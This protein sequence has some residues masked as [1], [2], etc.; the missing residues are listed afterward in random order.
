VITSFVHALQILVSVVFLYI[1]LVVILSEI[2]ATENLGVQLADLIFKPLGTLFNN[3]VSYLPTLFNIAVII[4]FARYLIKAIRY[5]TKG[6]ITG[7][8]R[9]PGLHP[10]TARTTGG[11]ITALVYILTVI[12]ILPSMPG[13]GSLAF[14]GI[15]TFLGALITI[16]GSSVIANYMAGIVLTYM[17]AFDKGDWVEMDGAFGK[18]VATGPFAVQVNTL[19]AETI[20]IPNAK[21]LSTAIR[22]YTGRHPQQMMLSAE[23]SIGYDVSWKQVNALLMEA[24]QR[25]P[26]LDQEKVP[27]VLQ[28]KLD[29]FYIVYEL[30]VYLNRPEAKLDVHSA[31]HAHI[32]DAFNEAGVEIMSPHYRAERDGSATTVLPKEEGPAS[33]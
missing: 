19:K 6:V 14:N 28:K 9:F 29:D 2:P 25:T 5:L 22:N 4:L 18:I 13:Y 23:V 20:S 31:L 16:G 15:A 7:A 30:N 21:V 11:I 17:H 27:F 12:L 26:H 10:R 33:E 1:S 32:L 8:F 3:L 24:T